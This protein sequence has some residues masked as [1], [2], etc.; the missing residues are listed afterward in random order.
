MITK[1]MKRMVE[2]LY[3]SIDMFEK[4]VTITAP[5]DGRV[6]KFPVEIG[7]DR[8]F[9]H[10]VISEYTALKEESKDPYDVKNLL[11]AMSFLAMDVEVETMKS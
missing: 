8:K 11:K 2:S 1:K 3:A 7:S 9:A 10:S 5:Y 4:E 6:Y